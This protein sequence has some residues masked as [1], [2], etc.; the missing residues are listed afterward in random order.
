MLLLIGFEMELRGFY[1]DPYKTRIRL[2]AVIELACPNMVH[3]PET[4]QFFADIE[5]EVLQAYAKKKR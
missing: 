2:Q 1:A 4:M 5:I 3:T